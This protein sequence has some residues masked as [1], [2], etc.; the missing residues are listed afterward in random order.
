MSA[1]EVTRMNA[2]DASQVLAQA[3][4][5]AFGDFAFLNLPSEV[6]R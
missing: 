4:R 6:E 3:A 1:L 2:A 5:E